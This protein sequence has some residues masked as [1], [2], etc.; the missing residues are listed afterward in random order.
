ML[1]VTCYTSDCCATRM[2]LLPINL[3]R[4][5]MC[6]L[7]VEQHVSCLDISPSQHAPTFQSR[8]CCACAD[9]SRD[10]ARWSQ[11]WLQLCHEWAKL[12]W[13]RCLWRAPFSRR[14]EPKLNKYLLH[15]VCIKSLHT[16]LWRQSD[17]KQGGVAQ[18]ALTGMCT[19]ARTHIHTDVL[20][21]CLLLKSL[22]FFSR[23]CLHY[24]P[25]FFPLFF[26]L[27]FFSRLTLSLGDISASCHLYS[28]KHQH[29][30]PLLLL[31]L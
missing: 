27:C 24:V 20:F 14:G 29:C 9:L 31:H 30:Q 19:R 5:G 3:S 17:I 18:P 21:H 1:L 26:L 16:W 28:T 7:V 23:P 4:K 15:P 22:S 11:C 25:L 8:H 10:P 12:L 13:S 2:T 6:I